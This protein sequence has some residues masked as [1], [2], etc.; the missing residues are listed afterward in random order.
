MTLSALIFCYISVFISLIF[1][2]LWLENGRFRNYFLSLLFAFICIFTREELYILPGFIFLFSL[3]LQGEIYRKIKK[4]FY[5]CI[6]I[7][8]LVLF[9]IFLRKIFVL[10]PEQ[11]QL[12]YYSVFLESNFFLEV[13][14][15]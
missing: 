10:E 5:G 1:F 3:C 8:L 9:H 14:Q 2:L 4:I 13:M 12:N 6:P 11:F 7:A 15:I